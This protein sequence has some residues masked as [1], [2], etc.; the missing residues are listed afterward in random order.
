M[1]SALTDTPIQPDEL[2]SLKAT[3]KLMGVP[4]HPNIGLQA[5]KQK[6]EAH[7]A[8]EVNEPEEEVVD[9]KPKKETKAQR[10]NR[11]RKEATKLVRV[12]ITCMNPAKKDY[13]GEILSVSN[14][15][16]GTVKKMCLFDN[17]FHIPVV[18]LDVLKERKYQQFHDVKLP[19]GQKIRRGK[20][21]KE[22]AVNILPNLTHKELSELAT[23]QSVNRSIDK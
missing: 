19:N 17:E 10:N 11:L 20:L 22:F 12:M 16:I 7:K 18:L 13:Q 2:S 9:G 4:F 14:A 6:I 8:G 3:A 15:A 21:V 1:E 5:L 23:Q